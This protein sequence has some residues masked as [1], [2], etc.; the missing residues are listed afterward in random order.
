MI[1]TFAALSDRERQRIFR[2]ACAVRTQP[3]FPDEAALAAKYGSEY[4]ADGRAYF[5]AWKDEAPIG[6]CGII[7]REVPERGEAF[8]TGVYVQPEDLAV[9]RPLLA[10][11]LAHAEDMPVRRV[12]LGIPASSEPVADAVENLG[13]RPS[14]RALQLQYCPGPHPR[15]PETDL[16]LE[17]IC[18]Q[19]A[20][21]YRRVHNAAF[22]A[23]PN[24]ATLTRRGMRE[25]MQSDNRAGLCR[26]DGR[27]VGIYET[28]AQS[29][30]GWIEN[31]AVH[32]AEQGRGIGRALMDRLIHD[33]HRESCREIRLTVMSSNTA[34]LRL[35]TGAGFTLRRVLSEWFQ[36]D[37]NML[38]SG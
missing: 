27:V 16:Q 29:R 17:E 25:L 26:H 28:R 6:A 38:T 24:G 19:N 1:R 12:T 9:L 14:H 32:P 23:T 36:L 7:T 35:Y 10:R 5:T 31:I 4:F 3:P 37:G 18:E 15:H 21:K 20:G 11:A 22:S 8:I 2:L 33:L 13:F 34:A 30:V